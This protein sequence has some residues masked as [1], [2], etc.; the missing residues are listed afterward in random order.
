MPRAIVKHIR[1]SLSSQISLWVMFIS[2]FFGTLSLIIIF[3]HARRSIYEVAEN[4]AWQ[5][6][7][8]TELIIDNTLNDVEDAL[9][10][11]HWYVEHDL[12]HPERFGEV[13]SRLVESNPNIYGSAIA[14]E[15]GF[16]PQHGIYHEVY[17]HRSSKDS[18]LVNVFYNEGNQPYTNQ[19]W[20]YI[21]LH[22][23]E[24]VWIDP[25][26]DGENEEK[27]RITAYGIPLHDNNGNTVGILSAAIKMDRFE[28][29]VL[30][31][32]P[33]PNSHSAVIGKDGHIMIH[34]DSTLVSHEKILLD[35]KD[36]V[37]HYAHLAVIS[38]L[39]GQ[40][41]NN[42]IQVNGEPGYVFYR[43]F[44]NAGWSILIVCPKND[45]F[46][47]FNVLHRDFIIISISSVLLAGLLCFLICRR[48]FR[49][50]RRLRKAA[51]EIAKGNYDDIVE[52]SPRTDEIGYLQNTFGNMQKSVRMHIDRAEKRSS[53]LAQR[54]KDLEV[55]YKLAK[56]AD[57]IKDAFIQN[58][59]STIERPVKDIC[60][61]IQH[62][63]DNLSQIDEDHCSR[64]TAEIK[65]NANATTQMLDQ[66]I[67]V[68]D[69][70]E[71]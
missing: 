39:S 35:A 54:N 28:E 10:I 7:H 27:A 64:M 19:P 40:V 59:T 50:L 38:M 57:R 48:Q 23:E 12:D 25:F 53:E 15:P 5:A 30:S 4:K 52:P 61:I 69:K 63:C 32:K 51:Y 21:P 56:E 42:N 67:N 17:A 41:G 49:P 58:M 68:A 34:P 20:Y 62:C 8:T 11:F 26:V 9:H 24:S 66:L 16:Y 31:M 33:F 3:S 36:D 71:I 70:K 43:P 22:Q 6:L 47:A 55:T 60:S 45:I 37:N 46:G 14:F 13:L 18:S 44:K 1:R 65:Q 29:L 2:L